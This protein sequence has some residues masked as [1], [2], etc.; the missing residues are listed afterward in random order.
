MLYTMGAMNISVDHRLNCWNLLPSVN[1]VNS[2]VSAISSLKFVI[3]VLKNLKGI[4]LKGQNCNFLT[5][6][7]EN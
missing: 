2:V 1:W 5:L 4:N 3:S 6:A 7:D